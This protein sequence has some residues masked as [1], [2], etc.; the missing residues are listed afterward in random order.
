[1][2]WSPPRHGQ[3]R[4]K[5]EAVAS[6]KEYNRTKRTG[7]GFY[8]SAA[9]RKLRQWHRLNN[10]ICVECKK[11]GRLVP[12]EVV[13]HIIAIKNGGAGLDPANLQSLCNAHHNRKTASD[14]EPPPTK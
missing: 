2:P 11:A 1:M 8:N 10:P 7:Q 5:R 13:D 4:V 9:W 3:A 14:N 6:Q 12:A